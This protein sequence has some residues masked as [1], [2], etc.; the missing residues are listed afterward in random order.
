MGF[1][2]QDPAPG[3]APAACCL[4][5][6]RRLLPVGRN[7]ATS[8]LINAISLSKRWS[9]YRVVLQ[10]KTD[11]FK[12]QTRGLGPLLVTKFNTKFNIILVLHRKAV[13][14]SGLRVDTAPRSLPTRRNKYKIKIYHWYDRNAGSPLGCILHPAL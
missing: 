1:Q 5:G 3:C 14:Q 12:M 4:D 6:G 8:F 9:F 10:Y 13:S 2:L 7:T 11:T